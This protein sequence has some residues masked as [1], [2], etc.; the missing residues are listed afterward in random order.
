MKNLL[1][2][3]VMLACSLAVAA[4]TLPYQTSTS[5]PEQQ[6]REQ[7]KA[8]LQSARLGVKN[9]AQQLDTKVTA[10]QILARVLEGRMPGDLAEGLNRELMILQVLKLNNPQALDPLIDDVTSIT[11]GRH[12]VSITDVRK[13]I[14]SV[15]EVFDQVQLT[16]ASNHESRQGFKKR[17]NDV[18]DALTVANPEKAG[19]Y[20]RIKTELDPDSLDLEFATQKSILASVVIVL[21]SLK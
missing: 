18:V 10:H 4:A 6:L 1:F 2:F 7:R 19:T 13:K 15:D 17:L 12:Q 3:I 21:D 20:L 9:S 16:L 5:D 14:Q 11:D 8:A